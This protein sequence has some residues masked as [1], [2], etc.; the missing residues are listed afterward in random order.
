MHCLTVCNGS[1][2]FSC[3]SSDT[4]PNL[5]SDNKIEFVNN[6]FY[7][8]RLHNFTLLSNVL[9]IFLLKKKLLLLKTKNRISTNLRYKKRIFH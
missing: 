1:L 2:I 6:F 3:Q 7:R 9:L 5:A 8:N 4:E